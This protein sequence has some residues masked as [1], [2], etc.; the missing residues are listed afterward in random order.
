M[1]GQFHIPP[2]S[3]I[4]HVDSTT[5]TAGRL[6]RAVCRGPAMPDP[7]TGDRW[8]PVLRDATDP[9]AVDLVDENLIV[10]VRPAAD[11]ANDEDEDDPADPLAALGAAVLAAVAELDELDEHLGRAARL[12]VRRILTALLDD[13]APGRQAL[14]KHVAVAPRGTVALTLGYLG[15]ALVHAHA[16]D[17][18][19]ARAAL[20][21]AQVALSSYPPAASPP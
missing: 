20:R 21:T 12:E 18:D 7:A 9:K 3:I 15:N 5:G 13:I 1:A 19:A 17:V 14:L 6:R 4:I 11:G 2:G 8:F 16:G 10:D